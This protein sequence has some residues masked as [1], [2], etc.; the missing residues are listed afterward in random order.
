MNH[1][2]AIPAPALGELR[3]KPLRRMKSVTTPA[4]IIFLLLVD[5]DV[6]MSRQMKSKSICPSYSVLDLQPIRFVL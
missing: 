6:T 2:K 1:R 4:L 5:M 3:E